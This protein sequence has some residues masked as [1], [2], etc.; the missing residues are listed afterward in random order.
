MRG[1]QTRQFGHN[2]APLA[3][4]IIGRSE[5]VYPSDLRAYID[6]GRFAPVKGSHDR[7]PSFRWAQRP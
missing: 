6:I 1:E 7:A 2:A 5:D 3:E 4:T